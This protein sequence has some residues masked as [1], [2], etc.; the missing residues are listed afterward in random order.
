MDA[1]RHIIN[2][3]SSG[4]KLVYFPKVENKINKIQILINKLK[5]FKKFLIFS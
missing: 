1:Q 5:N 3:W 2:C 4:I